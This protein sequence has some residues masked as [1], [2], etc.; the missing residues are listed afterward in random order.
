MKN[1]TSNLAPIEPSRYPLRGTN[2][3]IGESGTGRLKKTDRSA[4]EKN[5]MLHD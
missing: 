4:P 2:K 5:Q 3:D 1:Y